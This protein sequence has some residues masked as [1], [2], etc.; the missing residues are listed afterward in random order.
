LRIYDGGGSAAAAFR[1]LFAVLAVLLRVPL[2]L[3]GAGITGAVFV[4][5]RLALVLGG[6]GYLLLGAQL[7]SGAASRTRSCNRTSSHSRLRLWP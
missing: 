1:A 7:V 5:A 6:R 4:L 3:L 2:L